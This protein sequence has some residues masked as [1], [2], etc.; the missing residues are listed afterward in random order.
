MNTEEMK[1]LRQTLRQMKQ[2]VLNEKKLLNDFQQ[3]KEKIEQIWAMEKK[4]RDDLKM[5]LRNKL[6][7]KQDLEEKHAFELKVYK[8]KVKHFLHETQSNMTD[9][10]FDGETKLSLQQDDHRQSEHELELEIRTIKV[11]MRLALFLVIIPCSL[12]V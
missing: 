10:R 5:Q 2:D 11:R 3:Q 6:R 1:V 7:Q 12:R 9:V 8:Q 4:R